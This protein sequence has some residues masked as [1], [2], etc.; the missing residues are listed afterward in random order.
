MLKHINIKNVSTLS[1]QKFSFLNTLHAL[2]LEI[3]N[4][5]YV[6]IESKSFYLLRGPVAL[7][8]K[9][10]SQLRIQKDAIPWIYR[11]IISDVSNFELS[12]K[13]FFH[14]SEKNAEQGYNTE[15]NRF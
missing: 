6:E 4:V 3:L 8:I 12:E 11:L 9:N 5:N 10:C 2:N 7:I 1:L 15:V 14:I 13:A